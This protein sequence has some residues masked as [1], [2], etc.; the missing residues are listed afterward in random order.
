MHQPAETFKV[1]RIK[2]ELQCR[3]KLRHEN[4]LSA[5]HHAMQLSQEDIVIYPCGICNGL[6]LGHVFARHAAHCEIERDQQVSSLQRKIL[7]HQDLIR[8]HH[9]IIRRLENEIDKVLI[10]YS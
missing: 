4:Y 7:I 6:H 3:R 10:A 8:Q 1:S 9:G 2:F 5:M